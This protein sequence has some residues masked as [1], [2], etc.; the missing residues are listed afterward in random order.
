MDYS[1]LYNDLISF[2]KANPL[3]KS[4]ET[5]TEKHH[6][7]PKCLGGDNSPENLVRLTGR[8][9]FIAHR[10]LAKMY[11]ENSN[12]HQA[13]ASF[14]MRRNEKGIVRTSHQF[15][16]LRKSH[17]SA[18]SR[19]MKEYYSDEQNL[20][21]MRD[22]TIELFADPNFKKRIKENCWD[23]DIVRE[24][25]RNH[26][27]KQWES[28]EFRRLISEKN[29]KAS[30]ELWGSSEFRERF[31]L[32]RQKFFE[33]TPEIWNRPRAIPVREIWGLAHDFWEETKY[34]PQN[35]TDMSPVEFSKLFDQGKHEQMYKKMKRM[36]VEGWIPKQDPLWVR[37]F[38]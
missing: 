30:K 22:R 25:I 35:S 19:R 38:G 17:S 34:N 23:S 1:K 33:R 13:F 37:D 28:A 9:H 7:L 16:S 3:V 8:E 32:S 24:K 36:F 2:R 10:L 6:I 11:P 14:S 20:K 18:C 31:T 27:V 29:S 21:M 26:T 15:E 5:Y 4:K 12:L